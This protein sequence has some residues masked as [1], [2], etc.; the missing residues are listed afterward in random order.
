MVPF[1]RHYYRS[2]KQIFTTKGTKVH[3]GNISQINF[4]ILCIVRGRRRQGV[5]SFRLRESFFILAGGHGVIESEYSV[6]KQNS[7]I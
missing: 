4:V 3:E 7:G 6:I 1:K 2:F 5:D